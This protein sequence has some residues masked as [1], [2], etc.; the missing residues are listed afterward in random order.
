MMSTSNSNSM[1]YLAD[2]ERMISESN[3]RRAAHRR[4]MQV[5][6]EEEARV[7]RRAARKAERMKLLQ[8]LAEIEADLQLVRMIRNN[9][10]AHPHMHPTLLEL[11][12][13]VAD[14]L[15][16]SQYSVTQDNR[17]EYELKVRKKTHKYDHAFRYQI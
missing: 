8:R 9:R 7:I 1:D 2:L 6:R 10:L 13:M 3:S 5:Q 17:D 14:V 4:V 16:F 12:A 15:G 11:G